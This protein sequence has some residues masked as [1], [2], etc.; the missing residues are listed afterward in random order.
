MLSVFKSRIPSIV[1]QEPKVG[2]FH[3]LVFIAQ[4]CFQCRVGILYGLN[5]LMICHLAVQVNHRLSLY[6]RFFA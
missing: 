4:Y 2:I 6:A 3:Y 1:T 5:Y